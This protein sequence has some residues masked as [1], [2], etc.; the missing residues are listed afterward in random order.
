[1]GIKAIKL[2]K[3]IQD[4]PILNKTKSLLEHEILR[5]R[6]DGEEFDTTYYRIVDNI[7]QDGLY[8]IFI[9]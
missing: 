1:M 3:A 4:D 2:K 9:F 8:I 6:E 5:I 7:I